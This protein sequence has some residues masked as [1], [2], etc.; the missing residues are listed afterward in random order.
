MSNNTPDNENN[1]AFAPT[2]AEDLNK[3][4]R[5]SDVL[6]SAL[7]K[8]E[9]LEKQLKIAVNALEKYGITYDW[10]DCVIQREEE[11]LI[12]WERSCF[13]PHGYRIADQALKEIKEVK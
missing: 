9:K 12:I 6:V 2:S 11:G 5:Q 13:I 7:E 8:C 3:Q 1:L 4:G 10:E